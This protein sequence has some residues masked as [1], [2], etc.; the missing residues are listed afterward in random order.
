MFLACIS[1]GSLNGVI[2]TRRV[3][4]TYFSQDVYDET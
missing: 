4:K 1:E 2:V 3:T